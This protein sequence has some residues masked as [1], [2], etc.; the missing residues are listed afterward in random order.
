MTIAKRTLGTV[1]LGV[2]AAALLLGLSA[3]G[4]DNDNDTGAAANTAAE[5]TMS[6]PQVSFVTPTD[7]DSVDGTVD[8]EVSL[9]NFVIDEAA[10]GKEAKEGTGHIHFVMD[11]GKYDEP[12][13]SGANGELAKK[14]GVNGKY[15][16]SVAPTITYENLPK[17]EHTLTAMLANNNHSDTGQEA[18]VTFTVE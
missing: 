10:V 5:T 6:K 15:S 2:F 18:S 1:L 14:L 3:C 11:G 17:G 12:K 8:A 16:P 13:Y 9:E 7:G 4:D